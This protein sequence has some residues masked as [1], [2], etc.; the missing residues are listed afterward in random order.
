MRGVYA[1]Q[2]L[3]IRADVSQSVLYWLSRAHSAQS[4]EFLELG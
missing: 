2:V 1:V 3:Q 4:R